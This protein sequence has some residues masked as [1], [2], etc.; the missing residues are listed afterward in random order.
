MARL[1]PPD[2]MERLPERMMDRRVNR[3][4]RAF[5][6]VATPHFPWAEAYPTESRSG[7]AAPEELIRYGLA[8]RPVFY[9]FRSVVSQLGG[10]LILYAVA[11][12]A[13][14]ELA[15]LG[16]ANQRF[17]EG[18]A[19][20]EA[21]NVPECVKHHAVLLKAVAAELRAV[22]VDLRDLFHRPLD[23]GAITA[24]M[25]RLQAARAGLLKASDPRLGMMVVNFN[26]GCCGCGH[27]PSRPL[28]TRGE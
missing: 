3:T 21:I 10:A 17:E 1:P 27:S 26:Q 24:P 20:L 13:R 12:R 28:K 22:L 25:R 2:L 9:A 16:S 14:T 11:A 5:L 19:A 6:P 8:A 23:R 15:T 18:V 7:K 4:D